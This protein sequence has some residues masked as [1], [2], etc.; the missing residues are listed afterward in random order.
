MRGLV[1]GRTGRIVAMAPTGAS[2]EVPL[3]V[4]RA[5]VES[6]APSV[7]ETSE[8]QGR[9]AATI[10][11][12]AGREGCCEWEVTPAGGP[13]TLRRAE[14]DYML[15]ESSA[16]GIPTTAEV[17]CTVLDRTETIEVVFGL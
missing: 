4:A 3:E 15:V 14:C 5:R 10:E 2:I 12:E 9:V 8:D 11:L 16:F 1:A 6:L 7:V 17:R 13:I